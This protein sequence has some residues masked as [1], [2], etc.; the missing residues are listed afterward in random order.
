MFNFRRWTSFRP[1]LILLIILQYGLKNSR[2]FEKIRGHRCKLKWSKKS[3]S[4]GIPGH[5]RR[6]RCTTEKC[7]DRTPK[8]KAGGSNPPRNA[9]QKTASPINTGLAVFAILKVAN[10]RR[11]YRVFDSYYGDRDAGAMIEMV[12]EY[13][14]E[15]VLQYLNRVK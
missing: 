1:Q 9:K 14:E 13:V 8:R 5:D 15:Q 7:A 3:G 11:Y 4:L 6:C 10:R 12:A 2:I